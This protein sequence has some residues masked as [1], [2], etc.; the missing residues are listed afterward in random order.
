MVWFFNKRKNNEDIENLDDKTVVE[1]KKK[2]IPDND[3]TKI[4]RS[5]FLSDDKTVVNKRDNLSI[6]TDKTVVNKKNIEDKTELINPLIDS[7]KTEIY[8]SD[9][10]T[11]G[12]W[13]KDESLHYIA[14]T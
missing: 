2:N 10:E 7:D 1:G 13:E 4:L 14:T 12:G 8:R 6:D 9:D 5:N 3:K 11:G